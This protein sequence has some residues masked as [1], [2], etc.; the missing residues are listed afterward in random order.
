MHVINGKNE[1]MNQRAIDLVLNG[2]DW[3]SVD[4]GKEMRIKILFRK[5]K[6]S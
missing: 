4:N 1:L 2:P 5:V 3:K 6:E